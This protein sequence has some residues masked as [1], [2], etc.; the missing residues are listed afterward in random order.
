M[1]F[2]SDLEYKNQNQEGEVQKPR[3]LKPHPQ[4]LEVEN[5]M[6]KIFVFVAAA[7]AVV[8][9]LFLIPLLLLVSN[10]TNQ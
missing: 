6:P 9:P 7:A 8:F 1:I 10:N 5:Q 2:V 3:S 4:G